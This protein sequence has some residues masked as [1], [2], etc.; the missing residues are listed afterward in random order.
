MEGEKSNFPAILDMLNDLLQESFYAKWHSGTF[1]ELMV[2][3]LQV[4]LTFLLIYSFCL[5]HF[6]FKR[7]VL[8]FKYLK[9]FTTIDS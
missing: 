2:N 8:G 9:L 7:I 3:S 4:T 1:N 5:L 6:K